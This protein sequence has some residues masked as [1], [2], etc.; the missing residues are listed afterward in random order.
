ML[1]AAVKHLDEGP[2]LAALRTL[3]VKPNISLAVHGNNRTKLVLPLKM[4]LR[5]KALNR[6]QLE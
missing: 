1:F 5:Y 4:L 2:S 3:K 6:R